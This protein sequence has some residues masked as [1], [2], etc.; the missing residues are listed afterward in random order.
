MAS[1]IA[2]IQMTLSDHEGHSPT[3]SNSDDLE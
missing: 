2:A 3:A 1:Q